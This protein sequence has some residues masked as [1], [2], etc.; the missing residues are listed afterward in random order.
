MT[1]FD[2]WNDLGYRAALEASLSEGPH[3]KGK[4]SNPF[5]R[6][7]AHKEA[8]ATR[9]SV[10]RA[11]LKKYRAHGLNN[12]GKAVLTCLVNG[13]FYRR[14]TPNV[15]YVSHGRQKLAEA[16][17]VSVRTVTEFLGKFVQWGFIEPLKYAQGGRRPTQYLVNLWAIRETYSD[18]V[19]EV[20]GELVELARCGFGFENDAQSTEK[21]AQFLPT[22]IIP[23]SPDFGL[24]ETASQD[25]EEA[26][27]R[28]EIEAFAS[29]ASAPLEAQDLTPS[30][31]E[32]ASLSASDAERG[33]ST[34]ERTA[35]G[36]PRPYSRRRIDARGQRKRLRLPSG[37]GLLRHSRRSRVMSRKELRPHQVRAIEATRDCFRRRLH[38]VLVNMPT[39]SGKTLTAAKIL[40][41]ALTKGTRVMFTVPMIS[42]VD[43]SIAAFEAEGLTDLGV[44]Q[45]D[46]PRANAA[47]PVQI[48]SLQ[49]LRR[50]GVPSDVGMVIVDEAHLSSAV[51]DQL[52]SDRPGLHFVG[53]SAT[54]WRKG[55][56]LVWEE[57][58]KPISVGELI[59]QGFLSPYRAFAPDVPDLRGVKI[60]ANGDYAA[61]ALAAIMGDAKIMGNVLQTWLERGE[62]RPTLG[63]APSVLASQAYAAQFAA[64]GIA[65]AHVDGFT[66]RIERGLL[67]EQF[68][69]GELKVIWSVRTMTTGVDLPNVGCIIDAA[70]TRSAMLHM[71]KAGRGLR[72]KSQGGDCLFLD[73]AGNMLRIGLPVDVGRD[74]LCRKRP[75]EKGDAEPKL[76]AEKE[77][78]ECPECRALFAGRVCPFCAFEFK[79]KRPE[80]AEGELIE[81]T[82]KRKKGAE[83]TKAEK[84]RFWSMALWLDDQR[85]RGGKLAKGL[86]KGKFGVWPM[87][88][89]PARLPGDMAFLSYEQASRIRYAKSKARAEGRA[90]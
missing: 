73:H 21:T 13:G 77:P 11:G 44:I 45:A 31:N 76:A 56:G 41:M 90:A 85:Q 24:T 36:Q 3:A 32:T 1:P 55:M 25:C 19:K 63:F 48:A 12:N 68:R 52:M 84:Q 54:P 20:E 69:T 87:G 26:L 39:G 62:A 75:D 8:Q 30:E 49:T 58:V 37:K 43:Q 70:P 10:K 86:Y 66:D 4:S 14:I 17:G 67:A 80:A 22:Y 59:D 46:H 81:I 42:L 2:C 78:H 15:G 47:A 16:A 18:K 5:L 33:P 88:L 35:H 74:D 79:A 65:S 28:D 61:E 60:G 34:R 50:R 53:L 7:N 72:I 29:S 71:Q 57:M 89:S 83:P 64:A 9:R 40:D 23:A 38:R 51:V 82:G 6:T 27:S